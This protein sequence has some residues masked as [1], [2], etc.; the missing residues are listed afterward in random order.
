MKLLSRAKINL[1]L[2]IKGK[3]P[4][5]F[6]ELETLMCPLSL[7]DEI[8]LTKTPSEIT[9]EVIGMNLPLGPENLAYRAADA[10]RKRSKTDQGVH[11]RLKKRI[12]AGGGLAGGSSNAASV[13][14]GVNR[15]WDSGLTS[16]ELHEI[17]ASLGSDINFFLEEGPSVCR[18]RGELLTPTQI[19]QSLPVLLINPGFGVSTPWAFKAYAA[20]PTVGISGR[21][22]LC[23]QPAS[24]SEPLTFQLQND[25]EPVVTGKF[26]WLAAAKDWL[27]RQSEV[28]DA[29][30]SGSGATLF[31]ICSSEEALNS[32]QAKAVSFFGS[33]VW[34]K[35]AKMLN[36]HSETT[37]DK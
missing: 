26:L 7:H 12:P 22:T 36:T 30:M 35:A 31:A 23:H 37:E 27:L 33:T 29:L 28:Q 4:D 13:L 6:H 25:L 10:V 18:G 11:I 3:R 2:K 16:S 21:L 17:A 34:I 20:A 9:L 8:E 32:L 1:Y 24:A 5:G 19:N 15:L 14:L